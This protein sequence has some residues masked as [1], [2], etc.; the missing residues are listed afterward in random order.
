MK[1][2]EIVLILTVEV[3]CV[4]KCKILRFV[5]GAG[6]STCPKDAV[7]ELDAGWSIVSWKMKHLP[8]RGGT[9]PWRYRSVCFI[10]QR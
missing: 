2:P 5:P 6:S 10:V 8:A 7:G 1:V 4:R 3:I 9:P